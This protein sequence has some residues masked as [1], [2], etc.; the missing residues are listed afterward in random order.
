MR[1]AEKYGLRLRDTGYGLRII[2]RMSLAMA[3]I[4]DWVDDMMN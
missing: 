3:S 2:K 1:K 4:G